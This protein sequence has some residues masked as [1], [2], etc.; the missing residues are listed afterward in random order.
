MTTQ[1]SVISELLKELSLFAVYVRTRHR[2]I[3]D[4]GDSEQGEHGPFR[5]WVS[6]LG[7]GDVATLLKSFTASAYWPLI[8][9]MLMVD[10]ITSTRGI[11]HDLSLYMVFDTAAE[12]MSLLSESV[13]QRWQMEYLSLE[14]NTDD[15]RIHRADLE[16]MQSLCTSLKIDDQ[17]GGEVTIDGDGR[18]QQLLDVL[19]GGCCFL[20][21]PVAFR[22]SALKVT[23]WLILSPRFTAGQFVAS[24]LEVLLWDMW[25]AHSTPTQTTIQTLAQTQPAAQIACASTTN[26]VENTSNCQYKLHLAVSSFPSV[27]HGL[28][29]AARSTLLDMMKSTDVEKLNYIFSATHKR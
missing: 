25:D 15:R 9:D 23:P 3:S 19:S 4:G 18:L 20:R 10:L 14:R 27:R 8:K 12:S 5:H 28:M 13:Q 16:L 17:A 26:T 2:R 21:P 24:A 22:Q 7:T 11:A 1:K 6:T 29:H